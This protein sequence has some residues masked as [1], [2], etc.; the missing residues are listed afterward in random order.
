MKK[1]S[2]IVLLGAMIA[3]CDA[4][5]VLC[6]SMGL[7]GSR[8]LVDQKVIV[9]F[10]PSLSQEEIERIKTKYGLTLIKDSIKKHDRANKNNQRQPMLST[11]QHQDPQAVIENLNKCDGVVFAEQDAYAWAFMTPDDTY[12]A[13]Y[14]WHLKDINMEEAWDI[15]SGEGVLVAV[16]DTGIRQSLEDMEGTKFVDGYDFVNKD[17]DPDDDEGHGSHVAGTIAQS[18]NN[19]LGVSGI[20]YN[21]SLMPIKVLDADGEGYYSDIVDGIY[22][23]VDNGADIIN[24]SLGG[25]ENLQSME[26]AVD[27]AW[28]HGVLIVGASGNDS[29]SSPTYPAAYDNV[30]SVSA[31]TYDN[32]LASY[33]NY[34]DT[35]DICAPGG[36]D[37]D[38]NGDGYVDYI[39]QNTFSESGRHSREGYYFMAGTSCAAPHVSGVAA[40]VK[41]VNLDLDASDIREI[42]ESSAVDLGDSGWDSSFGHGKI[43][44]YAAAMLALDYTAEDDGTSPVIENV[45]AINVTSTSADI[46]WTTDEASTGTVYYGQTADLGSVASSSDR[47]VVSHV[48]SLTGL[49][50]DTVINFK[51]VSADSFSNESESEVLSFTT[52]SEDEETEANTIFVSGIEMRRFQQH[53]MLTYAMARI[54]VVDGQ[55]NAVSGALVN[56]SWSG[57]V[58]A[59]GAAYTDRNGFAIFESPF[60]MGFRPAFTITVDDV[61]HGSYSYDPAGNSETS[62]SI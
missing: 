53:R 23:A 12:Y 6:Q 1:I 10:D 31:T 5:A 9:Q 56:V 43:D 7:R 19:G 18:T 41:S 46:S 8:K 52:L 55:G 48:V 26:E 36:D 14:Q 3:I 39:L 47:R 61:S 4:T 40:L 51:V 30:L 58:R 11:F 17:D 22:W 35:I 59:R 37:G 34:G 32:T 44:A 2:V 25:E 27:Y 16:I 54:A 42:L 57:S 29:S 20:A 38:A 28:E 62:D 13:P 60:S 24:L 21:C 45:E 33:S 15:A 49:P 50:A